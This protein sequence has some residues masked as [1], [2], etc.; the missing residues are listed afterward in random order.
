M[1]AISEQRL[2]LVN[3]ALAVKVRTANDAL[4]AQTGNGFRVASGLRNYEQQTAL[5][6]QGRTT[7]GEKVTNA[8]AGYSNHNFGCAVDCYPFLLA[9]AGAIDITD[10]NEPQFK[11]MVEALKAEGLAWGGDWKDICD[12]P[13]FQLANVPVT[14]TEADR[15][16]FAAGGLEAVWVQ[17]A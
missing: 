1:E 5:Y 4:I 14:P 9:D 8:P 12:E 11:A 3:P 16:A 15:A 7:P 13:H 17:Y 10:P 2:A 6:A